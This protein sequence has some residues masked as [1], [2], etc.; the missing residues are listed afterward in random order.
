LQEGG[1]L[2]FADFLQKHG[3]LFE[4]ANFNKYNSNAAKFYRRNLENIVQ[5]LTNSEN[6]NENKNINEEQ[7]NLNSPE[8]FTL[9]SPYFFINSEKSGRIMGEYQKNMKRKINLIIL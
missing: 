9:I 2:R 3:V 4:G 8:N 7:K 1:N 5:N 6:I